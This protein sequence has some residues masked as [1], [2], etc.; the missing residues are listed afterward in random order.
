MAHGASR[1]RSS[2][3]SVQ[4]LWGVQGIAAVADPKIVAPYLR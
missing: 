4:E 2:F 3:R 1:C